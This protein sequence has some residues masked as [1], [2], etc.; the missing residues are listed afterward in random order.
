M[1]RVPHV[2][3]TLLLFGGMWLSAADQSTAPQVEAIYPSAAA[4]PANHL[5]FYIHFSVPMRQGVFLD[6]CKLLDDHGRVITTE[7]FR[8]TE[9]WNE[10][11]RRLT[12]WLHP[13]RQKT[14]VNLN[15]DFGPVLAPGL[16]YTL[17]ISGTWPSSDGLPSGKDT[18]K[19]FFVGP[20]ETKQLDTRTWIIRAPAAG[21]KAPLEIR[22]PA[23]L[24]HALLMR[25]L[26]VVDD[27]GK[28]LAGTISSTD[29]ERNWRFSPAQPWTG[30]SYRVTVNTILEDL[31]GNSL[32]RP[33]EVDLDGKPPAKTPATI[34]LSFK[35][36]APESH[37]TNAGR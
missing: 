1:V 22:F 11:G 29:S 19:T 28:A 37:N 5:K 15:R 33:F 20:R 21:S 18:T 30:Q 9:L 35:P 25:C 8:E 14:G 17:V 6:H 4:L 10:D 13:G 7:P 26:Q 31:A 3:L 12:L 36:F 16:R 27:N 2:L 24:D 32:A 34:T 23:P